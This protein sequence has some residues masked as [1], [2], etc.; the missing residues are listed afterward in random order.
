MDGASPAQSGAWYARESQGAILAS[1][2]TLST[3]KVDADDGEPASNDFFD[4]QSRI[5]KELFP[6]N[7]DGDTVRLSGEYLVRAGAW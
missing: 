1:F 6:E 4:V 3:V 7:P 2:F 5:N